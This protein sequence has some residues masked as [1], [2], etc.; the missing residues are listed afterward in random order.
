MQNE[1][2]IIARIQKGDSEDFGILYDRYIKKIYDFVYFKTGHKETAED[3]VS[4]VF[5]K[6]LE[7]INTF[8][9]IGSFSSWIY[10]IARNTVIDY[11][12][13]KKSDA[14]IE[15]AWDLADDSYVEIDLDVKQKLAEVKKYLSK[16]KSEQ[17]DI[18]IMRVWQEMSYAEI[19]E[20]VGKSEAS[21]KMVFSR[22]MKQLRA[23]MPLGILLLFLL[24]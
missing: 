9:N 3:L 6:A 16:L 8:D 19:A 11:Y 2:D 1:S 24:K 10:R 7:K 12:R 5:T 4:I 21:C 13:T 14:N 15:D 17:R 23:E 20:I 18:I 22:A